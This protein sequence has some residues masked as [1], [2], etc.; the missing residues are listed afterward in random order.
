MKWAVLM[1]RRSI[2][3]VKRYLQLHFELT[4]E[5]ATKCLYNR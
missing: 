1:R 2:K 4:S 3:S 5:N